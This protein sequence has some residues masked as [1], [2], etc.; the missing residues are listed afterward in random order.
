MVFSPVYF[1]PVTHK[2]SLEI[3]APIVNS[4]DTPP[5]LLGFI[6][7]TLDLD[8][9]WNVVQ[10]DKGANGNGSYAFILDQNGVRIADTNTHL[11]FSAVAPL[12]IQTQQTISSESRFGK[13]STIPIK[14][15]NLR[16]PLHSNTTLQMIPAG[17]SETFQ[18]AQNAV[19][20]VPWTYFVLSPAS[21]VTSVADK[22]LTITMIIAC[23]VLVLA[24]LIG[25]SLGRFI[26]NP[27][28][29]SVER[30]RRNSSALKMLSTKQQSSANEQT[31]VIDSA[32]IGLES[33]QYY[34]DATRIAAQRLHEV[35][36]DL[37]QNWHSRD[38]GAIRHILGQMVGA[39]QYIEKSV[40]YQTSSNQKLSTAINVTTLV[41]E[42]LADG[43]SSAS[44]AA[45]ELEKVVDELHQVVG[46]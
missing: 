33:V 36:V 26:S 6:R 21:T 20:T 5:T 25:L 15:D 8:Y 43:A 34:T 4:A 23:A 11:L 39:A 37:M 41:N 32:H 30:L 2:A 18:V 7:S 28:L 13:H 27:I 3:Y 10:N 46:R 9:I 44:S 24:A 22:Q 1:S 45:E 38:P 35:G 19:A 42:Q 31:W 14:P 29:K 40:H 17:Q 12:S 16:V